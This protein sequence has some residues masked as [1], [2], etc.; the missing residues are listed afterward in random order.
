MMELMRTMASIIPM[1]AQLEQLKEAI[2]EYQSA[3][4]DSEK[5]NAEKR[6]TMGC[7]MFTYAHFDKG[8]DIS[9]IAKEAE[10]VSRASN[11]LKT[12]KGENGN[13]LQSSNMKG[14]SF[15]LSVVGIALLFR[16][17]FLFK[18]IC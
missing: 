3:V 2:E 7:V 9:E 1:E 11:F 13:Y 15:Y 12:I 6:I 4:I 8:K 18:D 16:V 14:Y 5:E 10:E 17:S